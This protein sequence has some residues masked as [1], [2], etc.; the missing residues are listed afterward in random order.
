MNLRQIFASNVRR[1]RAEKKLSQEALAD[2]AEMDR[3]YLSTV[4]TSATNIGLDLVEKIAAA[5]NVESADLLK[6]PSKSA[7]PRGTR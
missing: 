4:E 2:K 6:K 1:L 7:G 3:S 5:L